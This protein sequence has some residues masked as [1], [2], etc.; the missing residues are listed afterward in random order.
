MPPFFGSERARLSTLGCGAQYLVTGTLSTPAD[1]FPVMGTGLYSVCTFS[2][3]TLVLA[4]EVVG[5]LSLHEQMFVWWCCSRQPLLM[6]CS[7]AAQLRRVGCT[8]VCMSVG[9]CKYAGCHG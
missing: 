1:L 7:G 6:P 9:A 2:Q 8:D 3:F 5:T 4:A